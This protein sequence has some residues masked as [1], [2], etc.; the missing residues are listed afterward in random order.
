MD[1]NSTVSSGLRL[2][3]PAEEALLRQPASVQ[4]FDQNP[5]WATDE[6]EKRFNQFVAGS[7]FKSLLEA[8]RK[9]VGKNPLIHGGRAEE[10]FQAQLDSTITERLADRGGTDFSKKLFDQFVLIHG[11][12]QQDEITTH[13]AAERTLQRPPADAGQLA[14]HTF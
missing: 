6:L 3:R 14:D 8:M 10:I 4:A 12:P 13:G 7:F 2:M 11:G 1:G 5:T 9:T